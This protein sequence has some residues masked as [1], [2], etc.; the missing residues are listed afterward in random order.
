MMHDI[1]LD[2]ASSL[3]FIS[4]LVCKWTENWVVHYLYAQSADTENRTDKWVQEMAHHT[5]IFRECNGSSWIACG[6][7]DAH[8]HTF[9]EFMYPD[10]WHFTLYL[11][12]SL[13]ST[14]TFILKCPQW[15]LKWHKLAT[16]QYV[17][18]YSK[19]EWNSPMGDGVKFQKD[20]GK[21]LHHLNTTSVWVVVLLLKVWGF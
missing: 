8:K 18:K 1:L 12:F 6:F 14:L 10:P 4:Q 20:W 16:E 17:T 9:C 7:S 21:H 5:Q 15:L 3:I 2:V 11:L 19:N 13:T